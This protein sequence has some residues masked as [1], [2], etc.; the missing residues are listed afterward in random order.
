MG[1]EDKTGPNDARRAVWALGYVFFVFFC[2]LMNIVYFIQVLFIFS[3]DEEGLYGRREQKR[4]QTTQVSFF[5]YKC[6][7]KFFFITKYDN[8]EHGVGFGAMDKDRDEEDEGWGSRR[9]PQVCFIFISILYCTVI[10]NI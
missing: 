5:K 3:L 4:A 7:F 9:E 10:K 1:C 6:F 2:I 8:R